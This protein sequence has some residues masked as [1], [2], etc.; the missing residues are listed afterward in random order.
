MPPIGAG[1]RSGS[2]RQLLG[3]GENF[4]EKSTLSIG[5]ETADEFD[6]EPHRPDDPPCC[7]ETR[8]TS[9]PLVGAE[10]RCRNTSSM[11][12]IGL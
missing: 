5:V 10:D 6:P 3:K 9:P 1:E 11:S 12:D 7:F 8:L 2:I 4:Q